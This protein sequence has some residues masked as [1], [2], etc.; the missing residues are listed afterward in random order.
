MATNVVNISLDK[1]DV[2]QNNETIRRRWVSPEY[3]HYTSA[4]IRTF[5]CSVDSNVARIYRVGFV[6]K[7]TV[8]TLQS[9]FHKLSTHK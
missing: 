9:H 3:T 5:H 1:L 2:I 8:N 7:I 6:Y 4:V